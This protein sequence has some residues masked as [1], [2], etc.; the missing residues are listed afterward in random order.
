MARKFEMRERA[1]IYFK[2]GPEI[3]TKMLKINGYRLQEFKQ[4]C[5]FNGHGYAMHKN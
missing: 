5:L 2:E 3:R 4:K 1:A